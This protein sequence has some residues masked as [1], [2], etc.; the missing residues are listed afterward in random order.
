MLEI[1]AKNYIYI[2]NFQKQMFH[3]IP[4]HCAPAL[5][6]KKL[7]G[8]SFSLFKCLE[9]YQIVVPIFATWINIYIYTY[10]YYRTNLKMEKIQNKEIR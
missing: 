2:E 8:F 6:S 9:F 1:F 7:F 3:L 5:K 4:H 10:T